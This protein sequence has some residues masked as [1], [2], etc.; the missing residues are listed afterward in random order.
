MG[1]SIIM[2]PH[3]SRELEDFLLFVETGK[4]MKAPGRIVC[5]TAD[6]QFV[7]ICKPGLRLEKLPMADLEVLYEGKDDTVEK[8]EGEN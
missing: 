3:P 7:Y 8:S 5:V 1:N 4:T 6:E 2:I